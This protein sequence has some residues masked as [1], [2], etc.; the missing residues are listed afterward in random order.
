MLSSP[1]AITSPRLKKPHL[2][3]VDCN[4]V[5][6]NKVLICMMLLLPHTHII[7]NDMPMI[8]DEL[9]LFPGQQRV[10]PDPGVH[11]LGHLWPGLLPADP[12]PPLTR[13]LCRQVTFLRRLT[14]CHDNVLSGSR[15]SC[16]TRSLGTLLIGRTGS[17]VI[18]MAATTARGRWCSTGVRRG[19]WTGARGTPGTWPAWATASTAGATGGRAQ[20]RYPW[21][22][23]GESRS[24]E[25]GSGLRII[26]L[27]TGP[28]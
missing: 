8:T 5:V 20:S 21:A 25:S 14:T 17:G 3:S 28:T 16:W 4:Q 27:E 6:A 23:L 18:R 10:A 7:K 24:P 15:T 9:L 26:I 12:P 1:D 19:A 11:H 2:D 22:M 13:R